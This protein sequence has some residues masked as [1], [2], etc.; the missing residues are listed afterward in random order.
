MHLSKRECLRYLQILYLQPRPGVVVAVVEPVVV[1]AGIAL[2]ALV[3]VFVVVEPVV[4]AVVA[5][6]V[7]ALALYEQNLY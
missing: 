7:V 5:L 4:V 6:A 1:A 2:E 3:A